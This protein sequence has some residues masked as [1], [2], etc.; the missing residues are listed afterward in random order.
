MRQ[1]SK[2]L[3]KLKPSTAVP[4]LENK[5]FGG[6]M[7]NRKNGACL[8]ITPAVAVRSKSLVS[9]LLNLSSIPHARS[10]ARSYSTLFVRLLRRA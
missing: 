10:L 4:L 1:M 7:R 5:E 2:A 8:R 6:T 3:I 9:H